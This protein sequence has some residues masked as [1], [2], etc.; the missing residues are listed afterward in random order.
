M[1]S[2]GLGKMSFGLFQQESK[3]GLEYDPHNINLD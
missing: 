1:S 2:L 3:R